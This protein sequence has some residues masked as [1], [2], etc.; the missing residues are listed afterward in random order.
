MV[1]D[2]ERA[3]RDLGATT[4]AEFLEP[5]EVGGI[6]RFPDGEMPWRNRISYSR[7]GPIRYELIEVGDRAGW[8][9]VP[10]GLPVHHVGHW[11][12]DL[13]LESDRLAAAGFP[14]VVEPL[15][16]GPGGW[17]YHADP[18]TG[19]AIELC[20]RPVLGSLLEGWWET[21]EMGG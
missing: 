21:G 12:D 2:I 19:I 17:C 4:G 18:H 14:L 11:V 8:E 5:V 20:A 7:S 9:T 1:D 6:C 15:D 3:S 13:Q 10:G 16:E